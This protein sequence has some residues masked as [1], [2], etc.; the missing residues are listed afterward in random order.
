MNEERCPICSFSPA[1]Y[2]QGVD[3][4]DFDCPRCGPYMITGSA[5]VPV[6]HALEQ[7]DQKYKPVSLWIRQHKENGQEPP[8]IASYILEEALGNIQTYSPQQK[9]LLLMRSI[10]RRTKYPGFEVELNS[11][12]DFP[13]IWAESEIEFDYFLN[14]LQDRALISLETAFGGIRSIVIQTN[15]WEYLEQHGSQTGFLDRGFVA[16]S[17]DEALEPIWEEGIKPAVEAA[18]YKAHRVD[19]E[20][21]VDRIDAKIIAD[22]LDSRFVIADVTDQKRGVYFEAGFALG[23]KLPVI[24][25][26]REDQLADVHFDTRQY[27]H[28]VW[29]SADDLKEN[30]FNLI[31]ATVGK[32]KTY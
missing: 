6:L 21:H 3:K 30:L 28:I 13:I 5:E 23:L 25:C 17:F 20:P 14:S 19:K 29:N 11:E 2:R 27:N 26:V 31:C 16:M 7:G 8:Q 1:P 32:F 10:E 15:G 4:K 9:I 24:W 22:I 18:G 12:K